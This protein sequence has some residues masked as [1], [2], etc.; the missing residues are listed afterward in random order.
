MSA[1]VTRQHIIF[2]DDDSPDGTW[3]EVRRLATADG[4]IRCIR[5]VGR[6]GLASA[7]V[8]GAMAASAAPV[9]STAASDD[10]IN[11]TR[12]IFTSAAAGTGHCAPRCER[13]PPS[14]RRP[15]AYRRSA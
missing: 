15:S 6:K 5:R 4:H 11:T 7:V 1:F 3:R 14:R 9:S 8:E 2:V 10:P 12:A 13:T